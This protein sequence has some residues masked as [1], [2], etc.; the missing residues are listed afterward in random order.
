[1]IPRANPTFYKLPQDLKALFM[2]G[3]PLDYLSDKTKEFQFKNEK[4][5]TKVLS[6]AQQEK[7]FRQFR[8]VPLGEQHFIIFNSSPTDH[9][10]LQCATNLLKKN[11]KEGFHEFEFVNPRENLPHRDKIKSL[12]VILGCHG[13]DV[14]L[15]HAIRKW[16]RTPLGA[17]IWLILTSP[18]PISWTKENLGIVPN[19]LF[20]LKTA[21]ISVG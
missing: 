2:T 5:G 8:E 11:H 20:S 14:E 4:N 10:A 6:A 21:A 9:E 12:Y 19:F 13:K 17:S 15:A 1:V 3:M 16:V 18:E 7:T